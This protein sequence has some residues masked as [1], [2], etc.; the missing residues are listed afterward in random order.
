VLSFA[1][2]FDAMKP[3]R[4]VKCVRAVCAESLAS[5]SCG[6][7]CGMDSLCGMDSDMIGFRVHRDIT[8]A[9]VEDDRY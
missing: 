5:K 2:A 6:V 4:V 7:K 1:S 3:A 8:G 9:T